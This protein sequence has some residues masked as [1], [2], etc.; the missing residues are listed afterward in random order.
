M[1]LKGREI[2][3]FLAAPRPEVLAVLFYGPDA[4]RVS[5][6][7]K[8]LVAKVSGDSEDPF[9][10]VEL[11]RRDIAED[12]RRLADELAAIPMSGG[13][14]IV[15]LRDAGDD[16][17]SHLADSIPPEGD[18]GLLVVEAGD[19]PPRSALRKFFEGHERAAAIACYL[20][21][22]KSLPALIKV[23]L[24]ENHLTATADA[25]AVLVRSMGSDRLVTRQELDKLVHY[26]GVHAGGEGDRR[27]VTLDDVRAC[28]GDSAEVT[29]D[30]LAFA[31]AAGDMA[32]LETSLER[33]QSTGA[34][35]VSLLR[36][37]SRHFQRLHQAAAAVAE[38][39]P[40]D[41]AVSGLRPAVFWKLKSAFSGQVQAWGDTR[42]AAAMVELT[43]CEADVKI[44]G[45]PQ[46]LLVQRAFLRLAANA[47]RSGR[48]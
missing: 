34:Q 26:M 42:L 20:D 3:S 10:V 17:A 38:G 30:D 29:L 46:D 23:V 39:Q 5:E 2:D 33:A 8:G 28:I 13:R 43:E 21:D 31:V 15:R 37:V 1:I 35:P 32:R 11:S 19:L 9:A 4:G 18:S 45:A 14:P 48:R 12:P 47:P 44:G 41:K 27:E 22:E 24:A 16:T 40:L 36:A 6:R 7:A 25:L